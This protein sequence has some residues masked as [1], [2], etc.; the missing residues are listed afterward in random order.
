M[1]KILS[2]IAFISLINFSAVLSQT[3]TDTTVYLITCGVGTE[4][5]SIYGHSALRI[6]TMNKNT[7]I[8]YNW[9]GFVFDTPNFAWKFAK[10][11]LEYFLFEEPMQRFLQY[12]IFEKRYVIS[13][14][15]NLGS[16]ETRILVSLINE[17]LK[18]E[19]IRYKY[20][21]FYDDCSTRIRDIIEKSIGNK[22]MYPP[23]ETGKM[24]SFRKLVSLYEKPY[25][26]LQFG[27]DLI[28]GSTSDKPASFRDKMFLP[29]ELQRELS[30]TVVNRSGKMI[31]LLQNPQA[32][33]DFEPLVNRRKFLT[34]PVS[35]FTLVL[36]II[37]ILS[38][39]LK[40]K[41]II[42]LVDLII[43]SVFSIL[44]LLLIFFNFFTDHQQ[45]KWNLNLIW[46][47]PF[48]PVCL[49]SIILRKPGLLWFRI[50]FYI[51]AT[52]LLLQFALPQEFNFAF[53]PLVLIIIIRTLFR[54]EFEWNPLSP[55]TK[56]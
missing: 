35:V 13:Q 22:L 41:K 42:Y 14:K 20:D 29:I 23:A 19:N 15:L 43:F 52:F 11:R 1:K 40:S 45:M 39:W 54:S 16:D 30:E 51:S 46:L 7:D 47:N 50:V 24:P 55:L 53:N 56:L 18:P 49:I 12:Y 26:W 33:L 28:M 44:V 8:V 37:I 34:S 3:S 2:I 17:N 25:P 5:Y 27:I 36:I 38:G 48:L 9:G 4:T 10:G 31:P 21:F 32:V 6:V